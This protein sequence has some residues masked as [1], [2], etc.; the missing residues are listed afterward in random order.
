[1]TTVT[2]TIVRTIAAVEGG[3]TSFVVAVAQVR[4]VGITSPK[5][6]LTQ[7]PTILHRTEIDSSHDQPQKTLEECA[8][9]LRKYK[10][11]AG[12]DALGIAMFGPIGLNINTEHFGTILGSS[13]K[14]SWRKV[15]VLR[16]LELACRGT[17][18][19]SISIDTDVNAPALAEFQATKRS[20]NMADQ[21][22]SSLAYITVGTGIGVGLVI[23]NQP[24]HGRLHPEGGHVAIQPL[25]NDTFT[26]YSWG[27]KCPYHGKHTV[28]SMTSSVALTERLE[29]MTQSKQSSRHCL[30]DLN[31]D[32][33]LWDHAANALANLCVNLILTVSVERIVLGGGIM[34]RRGLIEKIRSQTVILLNGYVEIPENLSEFITPSKFGVDIGLMGAI[35]LALEGMKKDQDGTDGDDKDEK[36]MLQIKRTA[37]GIGL[38][39]GV[40]VGISAAIMAWGFFGRNKKR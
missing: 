7:Q 4:I 39:H 30:A 19:L 5:I 35:V 31:D 32:H 40:F 37:Y 38:Q 34:Q 16:P 18:P 2:S 20:C 14:A 11:P 26:G 33:D 13:P 8:A 3:G 28:E 24:V 22:I 23:N 1:M 10:P 6:S 36:I 21:P 27:D 17:S 29:Q 9:F 25:P 15:N 12:Y